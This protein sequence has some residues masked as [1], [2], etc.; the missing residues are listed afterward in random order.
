MMRFSGIG[1]NS[2][3]RSFTSCPASIKGPPNASRPSGGRCSRGMRLP[4]EGW[5]GLM[6]SI[7]MMTIVMFD[8][9]TER[10][11]VFSLNR[12]YTLYHKVYDKSRVNL[13]QNFLSYQR[14]GQNIA[15][16]GQQ[17]TDSVLATRSQLSIADFIL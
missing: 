9:R 3:S 4:M 6:R 10:F 17:M 7:F 12:P 11:P 8:G 14:I 13:F 5:G 2:A 15:I 16:V 1:P